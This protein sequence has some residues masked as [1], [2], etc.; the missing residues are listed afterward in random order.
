MRAVCLSRVANRATRAPIRERQ[1]G[2]NERRDVTDFEKTALQTWYRAGRRKMH[3]RLVP[4]SSRR[5]ANGEVP[6]GEAGGS[7]EWSAS[8]GSKVG[9][10]GGKKR[11]AEIFFGYKILINDTR[12]APPCVTRA[13]PCVASSASCRRSALPAG[14][15]L[16]SAGS[17]GAARSPGACRTTRC[18][19]CE[20]GCRGSSTPART[21][22]S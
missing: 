15:G 17:A 5:T 8:P 3:R 13:V 21:G 9:R 6:R 2:V 22:A 12:V 18:S 16:S 7:C 20:R 11:R 1:G 4:L 14:A 19:P 10:Q